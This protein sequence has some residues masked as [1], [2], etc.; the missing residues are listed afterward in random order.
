MGLP[1][2]LLPYAENL[3]RRFPEEFVALGMPGLEEIFDLRLNGSWT[4]RMVE[5]P[6]EKTVEITI[7]RWQ[8]STPVIPQSGLHHPALWS[9]M[10]PQCQQQVFGMYP[11]QQVPG[12]YPPQQVPGMTGLPGCTSPMSQM[13]T[14]GSTQVTGYPSPTPPPPTHGHMQGWSQPNCCGVNNSASDDQSTARLVRLE[15][16][17]SALKPQIEALLTAQARVQPQ[18]PPPSLSVPPVPAPAVVPQ[19]PAASVVAEESQTIPAP[20]AQSVPVQSQHHPAPQSAVQQIFSSSASGMGLLDSHEGE[21]ELRTRR[22]MMQLQIQTTPKEK[23]L[24]KLKTQSG[25]VK[26][27]QPAETA[28]PQV[29]PLQDEVKTKAPPPKEERQRPRVSAVRVAPSANDPV[30]PRS[31]GRFTPW[32]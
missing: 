24:D 27:I 30:S 3:Y 22:N 18:A 21:N 14:R 10:G 26:V 8:T 17:L 11:P 13:Y 15:S 20:Q 2:D 7:R 6:T 1:P 28:A 29:Q 12:I 9:S 4:R 31:P 5:S 32:A 19:R 16:A 25:T 23:L